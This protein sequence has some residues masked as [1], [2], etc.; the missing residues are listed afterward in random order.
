MSLEDL[1]RLLAMRTDDEALRISLSQPVDLDTLKQLAEE[2]GLSINDEDILAAQHRADQA[3]SAA[4]LQAQQ[5]DD[6]R[7]LRNF[8]NG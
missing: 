3:R 4:E 8:V 7:R 5:G 6:A 2:R 1:D